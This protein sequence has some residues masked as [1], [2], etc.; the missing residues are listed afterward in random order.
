MHS[1]KLGE[2]KARKNKRTAVFH[3]YGEILPKALCAQIRMPMTHTVRTDTLV[4]QVDRKV[5][6][7]DKVTARSARKAPAKVSPRFCLNGF[8]FGVHPDPAGSRS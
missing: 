6:V 2:N 5:C 8:S 3:R 7:T 1:P 4:C